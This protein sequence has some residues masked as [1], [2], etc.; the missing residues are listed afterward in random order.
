M[1]TNP[2]HPL[3]PRR[4]VFCAGMA[5]AGSTWQYQAAGNLVENARVGRRLGGI[6]KYRR[7]AFGELRASLEDEQGFLVLK[8]HNVHPAMA[9]EVTHGGAVV[10]TSH[11]DIRDA[12]ASWMRMRNAPF[13]RLWRRIW[14]FRW[15]TEFDEWAAFP[16]AVVMRYDEILTD[17]ASQ[18]ARLAGALELQP[19]AEEMSSI[20]DDLS[21]TRQRDRSER[22]IEE[23]ERQGRRTTRDPVTMLHDNHVGTGELGVYRSMLR[24]SQIAAIEEVCGDWMQRWGYVPDRPRLN[25]AEAIRARRLVR[26]FERTE[27]DSPWT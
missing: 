20:L 18:L 25:P 11:R 24:P 6:D 8:S 21:L 7:S 16:S 10:F 4:F 9:G 14:P 17:P 2:E 22:L 1:L 12:A 15:T 27:G 26:Q 5:R 19:T 13:S 3:P 23:R